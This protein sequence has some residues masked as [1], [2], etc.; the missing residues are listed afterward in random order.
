MTDSISRVREIV[1]S[2]GLSIPEERLEKVAA[3]YDLAIAET[4]AVRTTPTPVPTPAPFD[5]A[6]S[7]TK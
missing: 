3:A 7:A 6:W 1:L 4:E 2:L 5:A